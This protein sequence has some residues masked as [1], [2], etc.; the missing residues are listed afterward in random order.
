MEVSGREAGIS[1]AG[2][3]GRPFQLGKPFGHREIN[4]AVLDKT[5]LLLMKRRK[6][7]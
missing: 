6:D 3:G 7:P 2:P 1:K 4:R 5:S